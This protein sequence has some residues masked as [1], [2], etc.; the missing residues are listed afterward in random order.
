MPINFCCVSSYFI[1]PTICRFFSEIYDDSCATFTLYVLFVQF[2]TIIFEYILGLLFIKWTI[3]LPKYMIS[4]IISARLKRKP[5]NQSLLVAINN[6]K[7]NIHLK[8]CIV[9]FVVGHENRQWSCGNCTQKE[10]DNYSKQQDKQFFLLL[11]NPSWVTLMIDVLSPS[12]SFHRRISFANW[13]VSPFDPSSCFYKWR[14][15]GHSEMRPGKRGISDWS[16]RESFRRQ[17]T[18]RGGESRTQCNDTL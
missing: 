5:W 3:R 1:T 4:A 8:G 12:R 13:R 16:I 9:G 2:N 17:Q 18:T 7:L 10:D 14:G 11:N 6:E 15:F